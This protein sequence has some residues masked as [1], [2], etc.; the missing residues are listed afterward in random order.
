MYVGM[1]WEVQ[2]WCVCVNIDECADMHDHLTL[3]WY[4]CPPVQPHGD[5]VEM[6]DDWST[7]VS[8]TSMTDDDIHRL[9]DYYR[10]I[11]VRSRIRVTSMDIGMD[12]L[13]L[14]AL[15]ACPRCR[16]PPRHNGCCY[17]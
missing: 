6:E 16:P 3:M 10:S 11:K 9:Q 12:S 7:W 1:V 13:C 4:C 2:C 17:G 14:S 8:C 5:I 15:P